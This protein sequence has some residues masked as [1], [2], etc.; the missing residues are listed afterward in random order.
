MGE[1]ERQS[2]GKDQGQLT[3]VLGEEVPEEWRNLTS[4]PPRASHRGWSL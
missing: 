1:P 2:A 4:G 3:L